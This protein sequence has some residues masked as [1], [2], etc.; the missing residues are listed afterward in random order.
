MAC[1]CDV[2]VF[3]LLGCVSAFFGCNLDVWF[4]VVF[5]VCVCM[6]LGVVWVFS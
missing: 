4:C 3:C 2:S 6:I 1:A 5:V